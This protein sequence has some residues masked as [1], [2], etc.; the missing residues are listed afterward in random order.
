VGK[1][2]SAFPNCR[3]PFTPVIVPSAKVSQPA[4]LA[5]QFGLKNQRSAIPVTSKPGLA[6]RP[7]EEEWIAT[8]VLIAERGFGM[9]VI[10]PIQFFWKNREHQR[11]LDCCDAKTST[12]RTYLDKIKT[13]INSHSKKCS[14]FSKWQYRCQGIGRCLETLF[15]TH[16][17]LIQCFYL[18]ID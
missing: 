9:K 2:S 12:R 4:L 3:L 5:C 15:A 17:N 10:R 18:A 14:E 1:L 6:I 8:F 13:C 7:V 11:R 16:K